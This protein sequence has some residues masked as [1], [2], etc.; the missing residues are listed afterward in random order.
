MKLCLNFN[1][2]QDNW[3]VEDRLSWVEAKGGGAGA[4]QDHVGH[5]GVGE[6]GDGWQEICHRNQVD[7]CLD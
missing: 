3:Q 2:L 1:R 6:A 5:P 7:G 4:V